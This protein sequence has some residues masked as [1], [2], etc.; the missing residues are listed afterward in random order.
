MITRDTTHWMRWHAGFE[1]RETGAHAISVAACLG[2]PNASADDLGK[3]VSDLLQAMTRVNV[4]LNGDVPSES[5]VAGE[6][7]PRAVAYAVAEIDRM[8]REA[9]DRAPTL[10][11]EASLGAWR[12]ET[13]WLAILA[14]DV[15]DLLGHLANEAAMRPQ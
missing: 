11:S 12:L 6:A 3:A 14:G 9:V 8:L 7:V 5:T 15:D 4:E 13:A 1:D 2:T 10:S